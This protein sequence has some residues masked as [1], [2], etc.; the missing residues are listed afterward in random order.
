MEKIKEYK[1]VPKLLI[2]LVMLVSLVFAW[3]YPVPLVVSFGVFCLSLLL[4]MIGLTIVHELLHGVWFKI[5]AGKVKYGVILKWKIIPFAFYASAPK[6]KF[7]RDHFMLIALFPQSLNIICMLVALLNHNIFVDY[8]AVVVLVFNLLGG[9]SDIWAAF[10]ILRYN[11]GI[12][13]EDTKQGMVIYR[14]VS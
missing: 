7:S 1:A 5:L 12:L 6:V 4:A 3:F 9:V 13:V 11:K 8:I 10:T 14:E 2:I